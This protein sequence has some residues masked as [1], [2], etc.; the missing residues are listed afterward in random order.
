MTDAAAQA[1]ARE[2]ARIKAILTSEE[3]QGREAL[4]RHLAFET[5][6]SSADAI[7]TLKA[8]AREPQ[9]PERAA[10]NPLDRALREMHG[11]TQ[12]QRPASR[13]DAVTALS[14]AVTRQLAALGKK[15]LDR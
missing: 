10:E 8:S 9:V 7:E 4:A 2:T 1:G 14:E 6:I 13:D 5:A 11:T 12:A 15:P 3:A